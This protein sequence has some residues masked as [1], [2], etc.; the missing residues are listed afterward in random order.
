MLQHAIPMS[1]RPSCPLAA[2]RRP[3]LAHLLLLAASACSLGPAYRTPTSD[4]P[5]I[6]RAT[7]ASAATAWPSS[8]WW[9]G[10]QSAELTGLIEDART[11]NFDL[12]AAIARVRQ[13]DAQVRIAG[14]PL[15]PTLSGGGTG[16]WTRSGNQGSG[17]YSTFTNAQ[18]NTGVT[19][20]SGKT[21]SESR[22]YAANLSAS[23]EVDIWGRIR[24][25]Q[26][27]AEANAL[28]SRFDQQAIALTAVTGVATTWFT[29]L[30]YQDRLAVA[31]RNLRDADDILRAIRGRA[32]AGIASLLDVSQQEALAAGIR[33][34]I[35]ALRSQ[36]EQQVNA[37]AILVGRPP[38][39]ITV[40]AGTLNT[41][42]LPEVSPGLPSEL[43][44]RRP[45]VASA[46]ASLQA[47]NAD[48]RTA[49]ASFFPQITLTGQYGYESAALNTLF[50]PGAVLA[51]VTGSLAQTIFDNGA[52]RG[53]YEFDKA[54]YDELLADYQKTVVQ[55]LVD[56]ENALV[57]YRYA[58]EQEALERKAVETAQLAADIARAQ[59]LAGTSDLVT[60][61]Q[62]QTTL[63][64]DLD[65]LAQ[66]RL[67]RFT[68]LIDLYKALGGGWSRG[69]VIVP[70]STIFHGV[71]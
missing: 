7:P 15:L 27:S 5:A 38:E 3:R 9:E 41:L 32:D 36:F 20:A 45:D 29:A 28:F 33:A 19:V 60:A 8:A 43:L 40:S 12:L 18:G 31:E 69:D 37:L 66:I 22:S 51:Q 1:D 62:A 24:S 71:L 35:P 44:A 67:S 63:F 23:W 39:R 16:T 26:D 48:I 13:A 52:L 68:A 49:R 56:V 30:A 34:Q 65:A 54:R 50:S 46:E 17:R 11:K 61:L 58:T 6:Y 55:A 64:S 70:P 42:P 14:A 57:A 2:P 59:L 21:Y 4:L 47:A 10:F 53:Q 25:Q